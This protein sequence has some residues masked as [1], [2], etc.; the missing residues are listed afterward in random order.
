MSR[1]IVT[2][3]AFKTL[4]RLGITMNKLLTAAA[5]VALFACATT[6]QADDEKHFD[7]LY[8]GGSVGYIDFG[9][10]GVSYE[11][12]L[13]F[14][15]QNDSGFVFG[16]EGTYGSADIDFL[17][18]IWSVNGILGMVVGEEKR[19]LI[20][21]STG[22]TEAKQSGFGLSATSSGIRSDLGYEYSVSKNFAVRIQATTYE[23]DDFGASGGFIVK[24]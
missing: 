17:D 12:F 9:D 7:G 24:F 23:F 1:F 22:Y 18:N 3:E 14:R 11:G 19:G 15:K 5:S 20:F 16:V 21:I 6:A 4:I 8:L 10:S 13:G 2:L